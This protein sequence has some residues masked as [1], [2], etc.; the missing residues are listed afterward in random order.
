MPDQSP[1]ALSLVLAAI[2]ALGL[3]FAGR[4]LMTLFR[5]RAEGGC[6]TCGEP[7]NA[8]WPTR[9]APTVRRGVFE[10]T[11]VCPKCGTPRDSA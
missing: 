3:I 8:G 9:S 4:D 10:R 2:A 5:R 1:L 11:W 7:F 6:L